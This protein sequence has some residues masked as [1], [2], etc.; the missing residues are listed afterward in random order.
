MIA[1]VSTTA[2]PSRSVALA[3]FDGAAAAHGLPA[4]F[5]ALLAL[6]EACYAV[7]R[8]A[9]AGQPERLGRDLVVELPIARLGADERVIVACALAFQGQQVSPNRELTFRRLDPRDQQATLRMAA[10]LR[11]AAGFGDGLSSSVLVR[12]DGDGV[13]AIVGG[14]RAA[15]R[16]AAASSRAGL[17]RSEIGPLLVRAAEPGEAPPAER[18]GA[19]HLAAGHPVGGAPIA[20]SA[21]RSLRRLFDK[22]LAREEAVIAGEDIEDIHQMR[23]TTRRLRASLQVLEGVYEHKLI[24]RYRRG[25]RRIAQA[26]GAV[27]DG[28]VFLHHLVAHRDSLP[29]ERRAALEPLIA[30]V[31]AERA[32]ARTTLLADLGSKRYSM[33]K[34]EFAGFLVLPGA[35]TS[36]PPAPGITQ[37]VRDFAGSAIWRHYELWRAYETVLP[38]GS[39]E[40]LHQARIAGKRLRYTIEFFADALGPNVKQVLAPLVALQECLGTL[41]DGVTARKHV[42]ALGLADDPGAQDYL[43]ARD[44]ERARQLAALP[45]LWENVASTT[46]QQRLFELIVRM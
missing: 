4:R 20:D 42:A 14:E 32:Q 22:L 9:A 43:A 36:P 41:Q 39:D 6:A 15:E 8:R 31:A 17:W 37:R 34:R 44:A 28:D 30:A 25:L 33:F 46:Y 35:G 7:A 19:A 23:V 27:R 11:V 16:V 5:R 45:D 26:L 24:R 29:V 13:T 38:G 10:I 12:A 1:E 40:S 21:R 2:L 18:N 3:L